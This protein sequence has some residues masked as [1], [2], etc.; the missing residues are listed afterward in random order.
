MATTPARTRTTWS[1][2]AATKVLRQKHEDVLEFCYRPGKCHKDYQ[3]VAL[4]KN[5]SVEKGENV[6]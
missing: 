1:A 6:R 5:L 2:N 4:S 3:V